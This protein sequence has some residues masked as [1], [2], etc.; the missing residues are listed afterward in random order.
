MG[1]RLHS[2]TQP[3]TLMAWSTFYLMTKKGKHLSTQ[4]CSRA[5]VVVVGQGR[6]WEGDCTE[7]NASFQSTIFTFTEAKS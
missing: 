4:E 1:I 7:L 3:G 2:D 6:V 5:G